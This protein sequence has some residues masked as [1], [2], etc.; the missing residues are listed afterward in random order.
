MKEYNEAYRTG[1]HQIIQAA[2]EQLDQMKD[3]NIREQYD[4]LVGK[5]TEDIVVSILLL[6]KKFYVSEGFSLFIRLNQ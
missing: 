4:M 1:Y 3:F 6:K 2:R 5:I